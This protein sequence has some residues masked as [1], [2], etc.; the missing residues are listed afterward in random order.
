MLDHLK[1]FML[2]HLTTGA[3][4]TVSAGISEKVYN[5]YDRRL[6][7]LHP[8]LKVCTVAKYIPAITL[9]TQYFLDEMDVRN[10]EE[11]DK[12]L[13]DPS[14]TRAALLGQFVPL[15]KFSVLQ[16]I[17]SVPNSHHLDDST[18]FKIKSVASSVGVG[19]GCVAAFVSVSSAL[20]LVISATV[21]TLVGV[22]AGYGSAQAQTQ[23]AVQQLVQD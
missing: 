2:D 14:M 5:L 11:T 15:V 7:N 22:G 17:A 16:G 6:G 12:Q 8:F 1:T 23:N 3:I 4:T 18:I 20:P 19:A 10:A 13:N 9:I 21:L